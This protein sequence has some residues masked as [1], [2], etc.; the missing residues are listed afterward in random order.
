MTAGN[1]SRI[2]EEIEE[3]R[4]ELGETVEALAAKTDV[5]GQAKRK[6]EETRSEVS[7]KARQNRLPLILVGVL[8]AGL[9]AH[10]L[11]RG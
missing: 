11:T 4:Q 10:R 1:P 5:A 6:L 3:T 8:A 2:R 7:E 9:L